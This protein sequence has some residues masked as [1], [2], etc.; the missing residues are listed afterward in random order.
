MD[1]TLMSDENRR[2]PRVPIRQRVWC[3]G[4]DVTLYV[5]T[6]NASER[7]MFIR[8]AN[9]AEAGRRLRVSFDGD[10]NEVVADVQVVW[11]RQGDDGTEPGMGV[12]I[13][14]F[15]KGGE[16]YRHM[17]EQVREA[18]SSPGSLPADGGDPAAPD[19]SQKD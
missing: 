8:T 9:P 7:G 15:E 3:E 12:E 11:S 2:H 19:P 17:V 5:R 14:A 13:L 4:E 6:L 1:L 16:A 18:G 10:G